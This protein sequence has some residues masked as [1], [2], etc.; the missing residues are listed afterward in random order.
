MKVGYGL[1][2][3]ARMTRQRRLYVKVGSLSSTHQHL[4]KNSVRGLTW[5]P[6]CRSSQPPSEMLFCLPMGQPSVEAGP[7]QSLP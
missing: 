1:E 5:Q 4:G 7:E 2:Q 3:E 6:G